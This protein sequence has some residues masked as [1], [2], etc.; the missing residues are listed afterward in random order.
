MSGKASRI[1]ILLAGMEARGRDVRL[2]AFFF[3][4]NREDYYEAHD[5]LE[6]LWLEGGRQA[7]GA[8]FYQGLIQL[9]G[10]FVHL[11]KHGENPE[12][13]V[14]GQRLAPAFRLLGLAGENMR[15]YGTVWEGVKL[16]EIWHLLTETRE[17]LAEGQFKRNP[18][19]AKAG[20]KLTRPQEPN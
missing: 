9:A 16:E 15:P 11:R 3:H 17:A 10:A 4:F 7:E 12:H 1:S 18:W 14:H 13:R 8:N 19:R 6:S 20:P 5:V 2:A